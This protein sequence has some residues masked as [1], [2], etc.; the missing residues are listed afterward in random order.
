MDIN[1]YTYLWYFLVFGFLGWICE[2]TYAACIEKKFVNRGFLNGP[3]C[4]IYGFGVVII[5]FCLRNISDNVLLL[6]LGSTLL[7]TALEFITGFILEKFFHTK[8]WDYSKSKFN[9]FGYVCLSFSLVWG[10]ACTFVVRVVLP[11]LDTVIINIPE[12]I[13]FAVSIAAISVLLVDFIITVC[14][15]AGLNKQIKLLAEIAEKMRVVSDKLGV[16]VSTG[17]VDTKKK[18]DS[19]D[20]EKHKIKL[21]RD[22]AELTGKYE[23]VLTKTG[24]IKRRVLKAFPDLKKKRY[25]GQSDEFEL[26]LKAFA[27][28][29]KEFAGD[30]E[31]KRQK[32]VLETY[33][34]RLPKNVERPFGYGLC[35]NKL[36]ILFMIGN[37][38]GCILETIWC[39]IVDGKFEMRVGLVYGPFIPVYGFG[40]VLI[41]LC[42]FKFYKVRDLWLFLGSMVIG[43]SFE[44][45]ASYFQEMLFGTVSWDYTGTLLNIDGRTNLMYG[46]IWGVLGLVWVKDLYPVV[47]KLIERIP[48]K[49]GN[50]VTIA[51]VAFMI[52]DS[53]ISGAAIIRQD[54]RREN[55]PPR[56]EFGV[57]LDETFTDEYLEF[58]YPHMRDADTGIENSG[59]IHLENGEIIHPN[60]EKDSNKA[61]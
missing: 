15:L 53:V 19:L 20:L 55:K 35:F 18:I 11:V 2:V 43:A 12:N 4:P 48:K 57:Y 31:L 56:S 46:L 30:V 59:A 45:F 9:L 60:G 17:A 25:E 49:A 27:E 33:E 52:F 14:A 47:S 26:A 7:T 8:W 13:S 40:A 58:I 22:H 39:F 38:F 23:E 50:V 29:A 37:V 34:D 6:F 10:L 3:F 1:F 41:T 24:I 51:L 61:K 5:A 36:F 28:N 21:R 16:V 44:Y 54:D 42:L 32:L